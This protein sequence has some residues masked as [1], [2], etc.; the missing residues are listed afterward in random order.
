MPRNGI[1][2]EIAHLVG[3]DEAPIV[4]FHGGECFGVKTLEYYRLIEF[5]EIKTGDPWIWH[6]NSQKN[7]G[8]DSGSQQHIVLGAQPMHVPRLLSDGANPFDVLKMGD[9]ITDMEHYHEERKCRDENDIKHVSPSYAG[10]FSRRGEFSR[11]DSR[12][13]FSAELNS[14]YNSCF[15]PRLRPTILMPC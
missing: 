9:G 1:E 2:G 5:I 8:R 10:L 12:W 6:E 4:L 3:F 15:W 13:P 7:E 11:S 14:V